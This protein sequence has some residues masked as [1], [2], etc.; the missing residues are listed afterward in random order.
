MLPSSIG[1]LRDLERL[2]LGQNYITELPS[3]FSK[4]T[5]LQTLNLLENKLSSVPEYLAACANLT[6]LD[7]SSN[8]LSQFPSPIA[9]LTNLQKLTLSSLQLKQFPT[10]VTSIGNLKALMLERNYIAS[11]P[12][13]II[14]LSA[15]EKLDISYNDFEQVPTVISSLTSLKLL[16]I[17]GNKNDF[18]QKE[19]TVPENCRVRV[20][21]AVPDEI[22]P[23]LWLGSLDSVRNRHFLRRKGI[24]HVLSIIENE[25]SFF[26]E[27]F[28]YKHISAKDCEQQDLTPFFEESNAWISEGR[29]KGGVVVHCAMGV[30]RSASLVIAYVMKSKKMNFE[31]AFRHVKFKREVIYPNDSFRNQLRDYEEKLRQEK[32][33]ENCVVS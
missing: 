2:E 30:S 25:C 24:T 3:S 12:D 21:S 5:N 4:L 32:E 1:R 19:V 8:P 31:E 10:Q 20:E 14:K 9:S 27:M 11:I 33:K 23:G 6:D 26:P 7:L 16:C 13:D 18:E 17:E 29:H 22:V 28:K 15:L